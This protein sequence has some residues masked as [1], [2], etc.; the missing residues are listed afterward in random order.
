MA[1]VGGLW[2]R[3]EGYGRDQKVVA[4]VRGSWQI[5]EG[6]SRDQRV[7]VEVKG[8]EQRSEGFGRRFDVWKTNQN[9]LSEVIVS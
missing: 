4:E 7:M 1:E 2:Q 5:S 9:H 3:S 6:W 8:L